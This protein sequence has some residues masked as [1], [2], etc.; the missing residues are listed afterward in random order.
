MKSIHWRW[1]LQCDQSR[2]K[3]TTRSLC[4]CTGLTTLSTTPPSSVYMILLF[5][6]S[7]EF[8]ML[9][10]GRSLVLVHFCSTRWWTSP[11][12]LTKRKWKNP[13]I[14]YN[15]ENLPA[16]IVDKDA[17]KTKNLEEQT[18]LRKRGRSL[19][20]KRGNDLLPHLPPH[21]PRPACL[22]ALEREAGKRRNQIIIRRIKRRNTEKD[23]DLRYHQRM[24]EGCSES[25]LINDTT[26]LL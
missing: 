10:Y 11:K 9:M 12:K 22:Q 6:K 20:K 23:K 3:P 18:S 2:K 21:P 24:R 8:I 16:E 5:L 26:S 14:S 13:R 17:P 19:S 15:L 1:R 7:D 4:F 25:K